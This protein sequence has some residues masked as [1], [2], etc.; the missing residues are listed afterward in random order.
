MRTAW[1]CGNGAPMRADAALARLR[2]V[3]HR[4]ASHRCSARRN[5]THRH[6]ARRCPRAEIYERRRMALL[7]CLWQRLAMASR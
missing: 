1:H 4:S 7:R 6:A 5:A 3:S 2:D